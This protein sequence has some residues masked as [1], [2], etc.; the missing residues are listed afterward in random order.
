MMPWRRRQTWIELFEG[1]A[2]DG[3]LIVPGSKSTS[4]CSR[5][6]YDTPGMRT[7]GPNHE[8]RVVR[9]IRQHSERETPRIHHNTQGTRPNLPEDRGGRGGGDTTGV[10]TGG[11]AH[12]AREG[13]AR[14]LHC[15]YKALTEALRRLTYTTHT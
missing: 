3:Y 10:R 14:R 6:G 2:G 15:R 11:G 7:P 13:G 4:L 5:G 12:T 9:A 1:R 8:R